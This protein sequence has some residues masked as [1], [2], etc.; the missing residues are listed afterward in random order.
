[1]SLH[2][3]NDG[4]VQ[5]A[6]SVLADEWQSCSIIAAQLCFRPESINRA[7]LRQKQHGKSS[8]ESGGKTYLLSRCL[9][10]IVKRGEA[11]SRRNPDTNVM[12]YRKKQPATEV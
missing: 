3:R 9:N 1:M 4:I 6:R 8:G 2:I 12:E 10:C 11:E 7:L 5:E